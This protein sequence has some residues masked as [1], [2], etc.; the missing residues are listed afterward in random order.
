VGWKGIAPPARPEPRGRI[1]S[2]RSYVLPVGMV[3]NLALMLLTVGLMLAAPLAAVSASCCRPAE[4]QRPVSLSSGCCATM[5][6]CVI[7]SQ[8][9]TPPVV[10]GANAPEFAGVPAPA[11]FVSLLDFPLNRPLARLAHPPQIAHAP[12]PLAVT[13]IFLI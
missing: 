7:S 3:R 13:G 1:R 5:S 11:L 12:P 4:S 2:L 9:T 6:C 10:P 8:S